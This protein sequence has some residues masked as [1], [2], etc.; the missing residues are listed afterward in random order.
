M[1]TFAWKDKEYYYRVSDGLVF[2]QITDYRNTWGVNF[3][4]HDYAPKQFITE[5]AAKAY[6]E[7]VIGREG[8]WNN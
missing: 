4:V 1:S 2:A 6:V 5:E 3:I 7:S 8:K